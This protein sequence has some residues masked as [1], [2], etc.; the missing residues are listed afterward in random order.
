[1]LL[2]V[3]DWLR[4]DLVA[5]MALVALEMANSGERP[6]DACL[7]KADAALYAAMSDSITLRAASTSI[8]ERNEACR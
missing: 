4:P 1:M 6:L 3:G 5:V 2:F 8:A 7:S